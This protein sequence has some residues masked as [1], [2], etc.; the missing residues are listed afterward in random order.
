MTRYYVYITGITD[1]ELEMLGFYLVK[2]ND[3]WELYT[4]KD[5]A[6]VIHRSGSKRCIFVDDL[7]DAM[8]LQKK[9][10]LPAPD[11]D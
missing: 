7:N 2:R 11:A 10:R 1:A 8:I 5:D 6:F 9:P 4:R 3:A